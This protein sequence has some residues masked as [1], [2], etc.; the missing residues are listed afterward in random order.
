[1]TDKKSDSFERKL[2]TLETLVNKL[3]QGDLPLEQALKEFE[4]GIKLA[5]QCQKELRAAEQK[6]QI[7]MQKTTNAEAQPYHNEE[8]VP[9]D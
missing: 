8:D 4:N 5:R 3:E 6:V 1:M 9:D 2:T 7:L